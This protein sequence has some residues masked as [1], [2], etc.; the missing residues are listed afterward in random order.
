MS[1]AVMHLE[2]PS[3]R[4]SAPVAGPALLIVWFA[5][6]LWLG[7]AGAFVVGPGEPPLR[8]LVAVLGP[9]IAFLIAYRASAALRDRVLHA[10]L[11][12]VAVLQAWRFGGFAFLA[13]YTYGVLPAYFAW[14]AGFGDM[15]IGFTAPWM[16]MGLSRSQAFVASRRF[17][18]WNLL[19]I[20][21]LVVA[22]SIGAVVTRLFPNLG[23]GIT[24][25]PMAQLPLVLVPGLFVPAFLIL[26]I[27]ALVQ[28]AA[29]RAAR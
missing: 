20:L 29:A 19:G 14:P 18:T 28:A 25:A 1:Q 13:L 5:L 10:D 23:G 3:P 8:L 17:V 4:A 6:I 12:V 2:D 21:D 22:I 16:L 11:R 7:A 24:T 15:A 26:H 27:V 9:V